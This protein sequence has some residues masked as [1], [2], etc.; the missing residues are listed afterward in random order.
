MGV[1]QKMKLYNVY[2]LCK[3]YIDFFDIVEITQRREKDIYGK[4]ISI[5]KIDNW[6]ELKDIINAISKIPVLASYANE[7]VQSVPESLRDNVVPS[8]S[9]DRYRQF[10]SKKVILYKKMESIIELYDSMNITETGNGLDIKLPPC[11]DLK[12][13]ISYLKE[14]DFIFTQCPFLQCEN[15]ILKFASVD[16]GSNWIRLTI[17]ATS[18]CVLLNQTASVLDK[19]LALRSHYIAIQQQEEML[20]SMQIKNELAEEQIKVFDSVR[21]ATMNNYIRQLENEFGQLDNP[22]ERDKAERSLEKL[23]FLLDKGCEIYATLDAPEDVQ[24]LFPEIQGNL[25]LPDNI[26]NYL[27]EKTDVQE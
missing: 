2:R 17:A 8:M 26:I 14:I 19:T 23:I 20:K 24:A 18:T 27:E 25:E 10:L 4:D 16:V 21:N 7:F 11:E 12:D 15:E 5:Y 6:L 9:E 1:T 13:Y 3:K 22:E